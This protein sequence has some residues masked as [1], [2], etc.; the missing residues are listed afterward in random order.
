MSESESPVFHTQKKQSGRKP[1][2]VWDFLYL[3][4]KKRMD[5]RAVNAFIAREVKHEGS[6]T[7]WNHTWL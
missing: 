6:Q 3:L 4:V 1:K 5:T 7:S 2:E